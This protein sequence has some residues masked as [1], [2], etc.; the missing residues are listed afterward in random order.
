MSFPFIFKSPNAG[1]FSEDWCLLTG[2]VLC[3][4]R[5]VIVT[6]K[7]VAFQEDVNAARREEVEVCGVEH[8][9]S[10]DIVSNRLAKIVIDERYIQYTYPCNHNR[11]PRL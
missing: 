3:G 6:L 9:P 11:S 2:P 5:E 10:V 8:S 4:G 1:M 7:G